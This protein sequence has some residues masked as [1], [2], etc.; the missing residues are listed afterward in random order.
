MNTW[1]GTELLKQARYANGSLGD[2]VTMTAD[3]VATDLI[4]LNML[5]ATWDIDYYAAVTEAFTLTA[6]T[7]AY[8]WKLTTGDITTDRPVDLLDQ[9]Y[10]LRGDISYPVRLITS[11]VY[12]A[13]GNKTVTGMPELIFFDPM[14]PAAN[15]HLYPVPDAADVI[16]LTSLKAL[17]EITDATAEIALHQDMVGALKWNLAVELAPNYGVPVTP[18]MQLRA[19]ETKGQVDARAFKYRMEPA[20]LDNMTGRNQPASTSILSY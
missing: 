2:G 17:A 8:T 18:L 4:A 3:E 14:M 12:Q 19:R 1:T 11:A 5:L 9:T 6:N 10:I 16:Y 13:I 15:L 20:K 7:A